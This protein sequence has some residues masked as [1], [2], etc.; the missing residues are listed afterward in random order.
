VD[1]KSSSMLKAQSTFLVLVTFLLGVFIGGGSVAWAFNEFLLKP[2]EISTV[3][4]QILSKVAVLKEFREG[5]PG[6]AASALESFL[7]GDLI[8]LSILLPEYGRDKQA[9]NAV[10]HASEYRAKFPYS[11][12]EAAV[13][14]H[15][16]V[17]LSN[18]KAPLKSEQ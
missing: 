13:D 12:G 5:H 14:S 17:M 10:T 18:Q 11:S 1:T 9:A 4:T 7:D 15:I 2:Q 3:T 6:K 16:S 8:S